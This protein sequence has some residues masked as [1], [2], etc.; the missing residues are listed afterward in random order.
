MFN[1]FSQDFKEEK[2]I[3]VVN[4]GKELYAYSL[5]C[6]KVNNTFSKQNTFTYEITCSD[7]RCVT[8]E[9]SQILVAS[10]KV[11]NHVLIE[12]GKT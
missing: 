10:A 8:L 12:P 1:N 9:T 3:N 4:T 11:Y 5:E 6:E 7:S 2:T